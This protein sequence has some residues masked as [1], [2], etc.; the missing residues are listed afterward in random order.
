MDG[1]SRKSFPGRVV[2]AFAS[3]AD[4]G[5][6]RALAGFTGVKV[7][8]GPPLRGEA[9][10]A[11]AATCEV[12]ISRAWQSIDRR[13]L[14]AGRRGRLKAVVQGS[15]GLDN[16][17]QGAAGELG[18]AILPVDPGNATAVAELTLMSMV[19]LSRGA[20]G[21]WDG[22]SRGIWPPDRDALPDGEISGMRL[23]VVG[24]GRVGTR[25]ARRA[26]AFEMEVLAVDPYLDEEVFSSFGAR[27]IEDL[28]GL[29]RQV[30]FLSLHCPLTAETRGMV[31]AE[32]LRLLPRGAWV[33]NTARGG[34]LDEGALVGLL[35][36]GRL[37]GAALDVFSTE[38]PP[39]PGIAGHP[40]ILP[41][42]HIGGHTLQSHRARAGNLAEGLKNLLCSW[43]IE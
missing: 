9:L 37:S 19:A 35:D 15:A 6:A 26:R 25:V 16:I 7:E 30:D 18:I 4:H 27:R 38:P 23:G 11:R 32:L 29:A 28:P 8:D 17:D 5:V 21:H 13:V 3:P 20:R 39:H 31:S 33:V 14:E 40:R 36:E 43:G 22:L 2:V 1:Q 12:L 42:P 10:A 41:T 34:I 24:L